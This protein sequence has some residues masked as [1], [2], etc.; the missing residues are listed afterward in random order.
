MMGVVSGCSRY[1]FSSA[2]TEQGQLGETRL[3]PRPST[4]D[5]LFRSLRSFKGVGPQ[6]GALLNRFFGGEG[7]DAIALDLL[8]HMPVGVVDRRRMTGIAGTFV[9]HIATMKLHIDRHVAP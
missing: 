2:A 1:V 8:M 7:Q 3:V 9:G 6:L 4:L 5:P